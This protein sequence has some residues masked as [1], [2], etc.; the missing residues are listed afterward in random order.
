MEVNLGRRKVN[1][2]GKKEYTEKHLENGRNLRKSNAY[3]IK[4]EVKLNRV[5]KDS[6]HNIETTRR[7]RKKKEQEG[8]LPCSISIEPSHY[9]KRWQTYPAIIPAGGI[10]KKGYVKEVWIEVRGY[11]EPIVI[12]NQSYEVEVIDPIAHNTEQWI[13][14][15]KV[16]IDV[17]LLPSLKIV[18]KYYHEKKGIQSLLT[19]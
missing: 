17:F 2:R 8:T 3:P 12:G 13:Q 10:T 9:N 1:Y 6:K 16:G 14:G 18:V 19:Q 11:S 5:W 7:N 15:F 4:C